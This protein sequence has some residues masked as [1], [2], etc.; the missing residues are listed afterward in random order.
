MSLKSPISWEI[1]NILE[2]IQHHLNSA[3]LYP[4]TLNMHT[5]L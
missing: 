2:I 3:Y 4:I 5:A 1:T